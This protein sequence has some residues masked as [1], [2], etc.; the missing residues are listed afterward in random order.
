MNLK[1]F[2]IFHIPKTENVRADILFWLTTTAYNSLGRTFVEYLEQPSIDK[3]EK[4]LQL[5]V[6]PSWMDPTI[7]YLTDGVHPK[8]F[9]EAKQLRWIAS[10]YVMM[11]GHLYKRSFSL[12]LLKYLGPTDANYAFREV[13]K[14]ICQNHLGGKSLAYKLCDKDI[15]GQPWKKDVAELVRRCEPYQKYA[16]I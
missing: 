9:V 2:K 11:N 12:P 16:K 7:Q 1:Y 15:I 13:H 8:D 6:E 3:I 4:V 14:E 10:Q 5:T